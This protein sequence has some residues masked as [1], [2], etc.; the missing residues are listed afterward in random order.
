M[1]ASGPDWHREFND[2]DPNRFPIPEDYVDLSL[3]D[4]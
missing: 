1:D 3:Q 4:R 2:F